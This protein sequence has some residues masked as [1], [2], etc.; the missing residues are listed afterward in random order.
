MSSDAKPFKFRVGLP[1]ILDLPNMK[2]CLVDEQKF[3]GI[4]TKTP[5]TSSK[6][7]TVT[8][9]INFSSSDDTNT[10]HFR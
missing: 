7:P 1:L 6:I 5:E 3:N 8:P 9:Q 4:V 10:L 2:V